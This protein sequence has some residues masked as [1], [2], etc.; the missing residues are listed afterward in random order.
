[1]LSF[2][3]W[4]LLYWQDAEN[5]C[6]KCLKSIKS[7][8]V[9]VKVRSKVRKTCLH[10]LTPCTSL[11]RSLNKEEH[12]RPYF[13]WKQRYVFFR[14][15]TPTGSTRCTR[16]TRTTTWR[17]REPTRSRTLSSPCCLI[18]GSTIFQGKIIK[19]RT[20]IKLKFLNLISDWQKI[21]LLF[22]FAQL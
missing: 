17:G 21:R 3:K 16:P 15:A 9:N 6:R 12:S 1:M 10:R 5:V 14:S 4:N 18:R 19:L 8:V 13:V 7:R 11:H 22:Q 2:Q 20:S